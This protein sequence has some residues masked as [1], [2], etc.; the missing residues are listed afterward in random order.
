MEQLPLGGLQYG[1]ELSLVTF[2]TQ[3]RPLYEWSV[4]KQCRFYAI[5]YANVQN[6]SI[7]LVNAVNSIFYPDSPIR[8]RPGKL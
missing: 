4:A 8:Y 7:Q 5:I 2:Q 3:L 6:A 1:A